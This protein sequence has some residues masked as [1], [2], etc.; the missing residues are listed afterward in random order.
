MR[1]P[2]SWQALKPFTAEIATSDRILLVAS[3]G[4]A[5]STLVATL[6]LPVQSLIAIDGKDALTL[7]RSRTVELP[8]RSSFVDGAG[9]VDDAVFR[10]RVA[11]ALAWRENESNRVIV[12]PHPLDIDDYEAHDAI[13]EAAYNRR[14]TIV[15]VDEITSTGATAMRAQPY[16]RAIAA[17]G[18]TRD[19]GLWA[20]TQAPFGQTPGI[21]R[22][23]ATYMMFG[24]LD[25]DDLADIHRPGIEIAESIPLHSGRFIVYRMGEREPMRL[26]LPIPPALANWSA[27]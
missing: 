7:P 14:H 4:G 21:V 12:R 25:P 3:T 15:W 20:C 8:A 22:R 2:G 5:K 18:R 16:L 17:R 19:V 10:R 24:P 26:Y 9:R 27:P 11:V 23:N 1:D 13:F 6:T